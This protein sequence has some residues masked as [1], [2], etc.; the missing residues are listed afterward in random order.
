[1]TKVT[2]VLGTNNK[3]TMNKKELEGNF[4]FFYYLKLIKKK[5]SLN[6]ILFYA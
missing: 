3:V 1:M 5:E 6:A 4:I 2:S